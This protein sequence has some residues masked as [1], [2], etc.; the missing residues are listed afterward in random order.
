MVKRGVLGAA[1]G[2]GVLA[3]L[4]GTS[5]PSYVKTA[6]HKVKQGA[7]DSVPVQFKI[8]MARQQLRDLEPAILDSIQNVARAEVRVGKLQ[9]DILASRE[10]LARDGRSIVALRDRLG[11][12]D[13]QLTRGGS[14]RPGELKRDLGRK[15]DRFQDDKKT[16]AVKEETLAARKQAVQAAREQLENMKAARQVLLSKIESIEAKLRQIEATQAASEVSLDDS[17]LSRVKETVSALEEQVA[18]MDKVVS[19]QIRMFDRP[20]PTEAEASRDIT[21]EVDAEFGQPSAPSTTTA[22]RNL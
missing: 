2:T 18:V 9:E 5:A 19:A 15:F 3:L 6:F 14:E 20:A 21:S 17:A 10:R 4:F 13:I 16:L 22:E 1:I 8:D 12:D 11:R 7:S